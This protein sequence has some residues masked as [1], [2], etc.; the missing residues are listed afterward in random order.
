MSVRLGGSTDRER[1]LVDHDPSSGK[2]Q[3][4]PERVLDQVCGLSQPGSPLTLVGAGHEY[5]EDFLLV[6]APEGTR[7]AGQQPPVASLEVCGVTH[8]STPAAGFKRDI[9]TRALA[10]NR[11]ASA[12]RSSPPAGVSR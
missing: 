1:P 4:H 11:A 3:T 5:R 10:C 12:A 8:V 7:V 9:A 6:L 2:P